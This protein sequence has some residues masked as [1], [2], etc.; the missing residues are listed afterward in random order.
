MRHTRRTGTRPLAH[1]SRAMLPPTKGSLWC[2]DKA[3]GGAAPKDFAGLKVLGATVAVETLDGGKSY[4][5]GPWQG[6][7]GVEFG[8]LR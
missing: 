3:A 1:P 2:T 4:R 7:G 8:C 5:V 6:A